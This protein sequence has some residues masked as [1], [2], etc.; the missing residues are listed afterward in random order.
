M[1]LLTVRSAFEN[2]IDSETFTYKMFP[3]GDIER[4]TLFYGWDVC[5]ILI[6][7][8][9]LVS[10]CHSFACFYIT[11]FEIPRPYSAKRAYREKLEQIKKQIKLKRRQNEEAAKRRQKDRNRQ[12]D[13]KRQQLDQLAKI[14]VTRKS[15]MAKSQIRRNTVM[16]P[17]SPG[18]YGGMARKSI[19]RKS[20]CKRDFELNEN[21]KLQANARKKSIM[22]KRLYDNQLSAQGINLNEV[23]LDEPTDTF[24]FPSPD[25]PKTLEASISK[26]R[27]TIEEENPQTPE[28]Q[29][30]A[31]SPP[32]TP[33]FV[34]I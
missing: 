6:L 26:Y 30:K 34:D 22:M 11:Q 12:E 9:M 7:S 2:I 23:P 25:K 31:S 27:K 8:T 3:V 17:K 19:A 21:D 18:N 33:K 15:I 14:T 13:L 10:A 5:Q 4:F 32:T 29:E 20:M 16:R 28:S 24:V 1:A